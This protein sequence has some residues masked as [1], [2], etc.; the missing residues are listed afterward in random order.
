MSMGVITKG[1]HGYIDYEGRHCRLD[2]ALFRIESRLPDPG[3]YFLDAPPTDGFLATL[4]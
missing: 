1:E 2:Y 4:N 3:S